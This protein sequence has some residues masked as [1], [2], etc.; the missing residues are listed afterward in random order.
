MGRKQ[1]YQNQI[2]TVVYSR[3]QG[4]SDFYI[5]LCVLLCFPLFLS[6]PGINVMKM[7]SFLCLVIPSLLPFRWGEQMLSFRT[8][9]HWNCQGIR[10]ASSAP[11]CSSLPANGLGLPWPVSL[12]WTKPMENSSGTLGPSPVLWGSKL[13]SPFAWGMNN[14]PAD[15]PPKGPQ[16]L[17]SGPTKMCHHHRLHWS[18]LALKCSLKMILFGEHTTSWTLN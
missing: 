3:Y 8:E 1:I 13:A 17:P 7:V 11:S 14:Q 5:F 15:E 9:S 16:P 12:V 2:V 4:L 6:W 18:H 10:A